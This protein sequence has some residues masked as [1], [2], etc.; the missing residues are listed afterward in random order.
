MNINRHN[1]EEYFILYMD[2][3]LGAEERRRVE[4]FVALHPDLREELELLLQ[5][6]LEP[7]QHVVFENKGELMRFNE[8]I[9]AI[10]MANYEEWLL[11]YIDNELNETERKAVE[12][13][14][15][16]NP[17]V[18]QELNLLLKTTLQAETIVFPGKESLYR[19]EE[20]VRRIPAWWR[21]AA[22]AA[23]V[24]A[25]GTTGLLILNTDK[26]TSAE[27]PTAG[28][29]PV[30]SE[31]VNESPELTGKNSSQTNEE[32]KNNAVLPT[33]KIS[34]TVTLALKENKTDLKKTKD[35]VVLPESNR[36]DKP[37]LAVNN[38]RPSNNLPLPDQ[39]PNVLPLKINDAI[40]KADAFT[41]KELTASPETI[42]E[43][44][45]T[46]EI[47][48]PSFV[49][50]STPANGFDEEQPD[51]KKNKL[52]GFLRK[53]TRTF[54][55]NTNIEATDEDDR[56]LVAGLAIKL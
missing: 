10:N 29:D 33:E 18:Q 5:S 2:N 46:K 4:E 38:N 17:T 49:S 8:P 56:L 16:A 13:F 34:N 45:V 20:K 47:A 31:L 50:T 43:T 14:A 22:A 44:P 23:I 26:T 36:E 40:A 21:F 42:F 15:S 25:V 54:E 37:V 55:K 51:G 24:I 35:P 27:G 11:L 3:E 19:K 53:I 48:K 9:N 12:Q 30:K 7:E 6:K 39:N 32:P 52:R 1:Y 41:K 28:T